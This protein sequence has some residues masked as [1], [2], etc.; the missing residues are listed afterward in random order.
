MQNR[1][2]NVLFCTQREIQRCRRRSLQASED[3]PSRDPCLRY[4][5][6]HGRRG[7]R[8][9]ISR[10]D[11]LVLLEREEGASL[12]LGVGGRGQRVRARGRRLR[13][14]PQR[15]QPPRH[16]RLVVR[17]QQELRAAR[18]PETEDVLLLGVVGR[19]LYDRPVEVQRALPAPVL[20]R[21]RLVALLVL[22]E[23]HAAVFGHNVK[24]IPRPIRSPFGG[25][26]PF[27]FPYQS[28][29]DSFIFAGWTGSL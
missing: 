29:L 26:F 17:L 4:R 1:T 13:A 19:H 20:F 11:E 9:L 7:R 14:R 6:P 12:G 16:L 8:P 15:L 5:V 23:R 28:S 10:L 18:Q 22:V 3:R 24:L 27:V 25:G 2:F 21:R